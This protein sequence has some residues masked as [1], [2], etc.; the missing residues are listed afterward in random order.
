MT[1]TTLLIAES[2]YVAYNML[3]FIIPVVFACLLLILIN[4]FENGKTKRALQVIMVFTV[5][6]GLILTLA[7]LQ[8]TST[9]NITAEQ[10]PQTFQV[11]NYDHSLHDEELTINST[12]PDVYEI[13]TFEPNENTPTDQAERLDANPNT[14]VDIPE[15]ETVVI[16]TYDAD[17]SVVEE[18]QLERNT[19]EEVTPI[20]DIV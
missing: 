16:I 14:T 9:T 7:P 6:I 15:S 18:T 10:E 3:L 2:T 20:F 11:E 19:T 1:L 17:G 12:H 4:M 5:A 8:T 13:K